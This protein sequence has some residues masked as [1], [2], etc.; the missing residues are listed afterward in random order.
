M[1]RSYFITIVIAVM[2]ITSCSPSVKFSL[3]RWDSKPAPPPLEQTHY[4]DYAPLETVTGVASYYADKFNG[5]LTSNG[6][7]YDMY[8][9][10]AAHPTY[11]HGTIIRVT[12]LGNGKSVVVRIND[13]MP[14]RPDRIIDLSLGTAMELD[15]VE[16]G[17]AEVKLEILEWGEE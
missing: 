4:H 15:M 12:N 14:Y 10:T 9:L 11:P 8:G 1:P 7:I 5:R 3:N 6:E 2:F 13:R 17:L 16:D